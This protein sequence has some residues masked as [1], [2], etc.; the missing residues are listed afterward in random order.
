MSFKSKP[1]GQRGSWL[2]IQTLRNS[3][4]TQRYTLFSTHLKADEGHQDKTKRP[5]KKKR[6]F[7]V[8]KRKELLYYYEGGLIVLLSWYPLL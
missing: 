7:L 2:A 4:P 1:L 8:D 6:V 3:K 5:D